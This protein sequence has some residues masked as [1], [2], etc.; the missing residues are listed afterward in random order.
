MGVRIAIDD[1][2]VGHSSLSQIRRLPF[3]CMKLDRALMADL[4]TDLGAQGIAA[5]VIAMARALRIRS[6]AAGVEDMATT[7]AAE[8]AIDRPG[9]MNAPTVAVDG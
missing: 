5:A 1:F 7:I 6:V 9:F 8:A 2:G 3:D 4:Y